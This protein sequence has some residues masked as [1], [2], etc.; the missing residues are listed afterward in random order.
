MKLV[1]VLAVLSTTEQW[2]ARMKDRAA[3]PAERN[4]AC[5]RLA[6]PEAI[7]HLAEAL[8]EPVV[9]SC[10]ATK[11]RELGAAAALRR[12]VESGSPEV[13]SRG[14]YELGLMKDPESLGI[15]IQASKD[16]DPLVSGSA[17]HA[18]LQYDDPRVLPALLEIASRQEV[19][20]LA[21][22]SSLAR[23]RDPAALPVLYKLLESGEPLLRIAAIGALGE[24]GGA[25]AT[26]KLEPLLEQKTDLH[27]NT[28]LGFYPS[29]NMARAARLA[30]ERIRARENRDAR[31]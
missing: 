17:V 10:A 23:F 2:A 1:L 16:P 29:I 20:S 7:P 19:S 8:E 28:G 18:L 31:P 5:A 14:A 25:D 15:L 11:L 30:I 9:R 26:R 3:T 4:E 22:V 6:S 27:P 13:R 24:L 21:A 12:A